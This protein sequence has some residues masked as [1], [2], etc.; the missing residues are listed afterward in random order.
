VIDGRQGV[1]PH[2]ARHRSRAHLQRP[3]V[4]LHPARRRLSVRSGQP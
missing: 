2:H 4:H 3:P 1:A